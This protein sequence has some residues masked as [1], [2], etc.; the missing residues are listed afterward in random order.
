VTLIAGSACPHWALMVSDRL[1]TVSGRKYDAHVN[2]NVVVIARD[3]VASLGYTG[4]AFVSGVA[5]DEWIA[6][7][8]S[9]CIAER[10]AGAI[11]SSYGGRKRPLGIC[12]VLRHLDES[13]WS[14]NL[15]HEIEILVMG[16]RKRR[17]R[18]V[19]FSA[20]LGSFNKKLDKSEFDTRGRWGET[21]GH[22]A[23]VGV[24]QS[25]AEL[26]DAID[27][28]GNPDGTA[29]YVERILT[30]SILGQARTTS[31]VGD[32]LE[33]IWIDPHNQLV[34]IAYRPGQRFSSEPLRRA[35]RPSV[36]GFEDCEYIPAFSPWVV[37]EYAHLSPSIQYGSMPTEYSFGRWR[38]RAEG[39]PAIS[40]GSK[41][42]SMWIGQDRRPSPGR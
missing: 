25:D 24:Y 18:Q 33:V 38:V 6:R 41:L 28:A 23:W 39:G 22:M 34:N 32:D 10:G 42:I 3:G 36:F 35:N 5:T 14:A 4:Q 13:L 11:Y 7:Q 26:A 40:S 12:A 16:V 19:P 20:I 29:Q 1:T 9:T 37:G 15:G 21:V 2:K 8:V 27:G 17:G 31:V 30:R